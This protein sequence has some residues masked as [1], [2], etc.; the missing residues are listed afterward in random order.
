MKT[1]F[2][3]V[4]LF[5]F[6]LVDTAYTAQSTVVGAVGLNFTGQAELQRV[7]IV[8]VDLQLLY[9]YV[10]VHKITQKNALSSFK[11]LCVFSFLHFFQTDFMF[12]Y[13]HFTQ[14]RRPK[15]HNSFSWT[16]FIA[17][18]KNV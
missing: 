3:N 15:I 7:N 8:W 9:L 17:N 5:V 12:L 4:F 2:S 6:Y 14:N 16:I 11:D 10:W 1:I 18:L 13:S